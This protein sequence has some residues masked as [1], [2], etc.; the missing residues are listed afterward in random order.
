MWR[1]KLFKCVFVLNT[2]V[3]NIVVG[4]ISTTLHHSYLH[5]S[6]VKVLSVSIIIPFNVDNINSDLHQS[7]VPILSVSIIIHF[8]VI[9]P[10]VRER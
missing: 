4:V 9:I 3:Y 1:I 8:S 10:G 6:S 2:D 7:S 5:R